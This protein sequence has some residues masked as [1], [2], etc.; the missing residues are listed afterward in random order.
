MASFDELYRPASLKIERAKYHINDLNARL[1][2]F[3][4]ETPFELITVHDPHAGKRTHTIET[5][6]A[7]PNEIPLIVG[8]AVHNLRSA[9]DVTIFALIGDRARQPWRVQFPFARKKEGLEA[10]I[11]QAEIHLAGEQI[12]NRIK[13][14]R[15][16]EGGNALLHGLNSLDITDKHRLIITAGRIMSI[17]ADDFH[18]ID[19]AIPIYG[20]GVINFAAEVN[21]PFTVGLPRPPRRVRRA[22]KSYVPIRYKSEIQPSFQIAFG[23]RETFAGSLLIPKLIEVAKEVEVL[24]QDLCTAFFIH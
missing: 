9:L 15:P 14:A 18:K 3:L 7:V 12:V 6:N 17:S 24:C 21:N 5:N 23:S 4:A 8:D 1:V 16:Y 13:A 10:A 19:P 11:S 22:N 20:P 2:A